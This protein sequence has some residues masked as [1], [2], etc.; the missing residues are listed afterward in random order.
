MLRNYLT[1]ALRNLQKYR[2]Y[3][4]I[5]ITGLTVGITCFLFIFLYI[6]DESGFDAYHA[7]VDRV[8]RLNFFAKLGD[9]L[10][11]LAAS[12][13]P[14]GPAFKEGAPEIE[15]FCRLQQHGNVTVR[16][17]N[18]IFN[19]AN[20]LFADS[21]LFKVFSFKL[22][23]GN[24]QNALAAPNS[25][26]LGQSVAKKYFGGDNPLGKSLK[27]GDQLCQVTGL[28]EDMPQNTHFQASIFRSL[29]SIDENVGSNWGN[30]N[31]YNYF[32]LREGADP[33]RVS[34]KITAIFAKNFTPILTE[35]FNT[36]WEDYE[37]AGNYARVELFPMRDIHL[38]GDL[39]EEL[40]ANGDV[41]YVYIFGIIGLFIL[42]LACIN[43]MN[44]ATARSAIR[45]KEVG[46]RK[47][48]GALRMDLAKQ[49]LSESVLMGLAALALSLVAVW[50][51]LPAFN[52]LSN[53]ELTVS[54]FLNPGF[55]LAAV[56]LA[57][58]IG[59]AAGSYPAFFL[60]AFQP[61]KVLKGGGIS[62]SGSGNLR[63]GLVVFQFFTTAVLLIGSLVVYQQLAFI[64]NQKLGFNKENV[65]LLNN[66]Y[67]L[68]NQQ[69]SFKE[70][71]LQNSAVQHASY[72]NA[73]PA[74]TTTNSSVV[75][76]GRVVTQENSILVNN[77]W[78]DRDYLKTLNMRIAA[79][80]D[81]SNA[82]ATDSSAVIVNETLAKSFGYPQKS[83]MGEE[84]SFNKDRTYHIVGVVKDFNF[85][86]L[87]DH[88]EPLAIY[89]GGY[90]SYLAIRFETDKVDA[91]VKNLRATWDEM[92]PGKPFDYAFL[93]QRFDKLYT[94]ESRMEKI[95]GVFAF[96]AIFIACIGLFGLATFMTEQRRRKYWVHQL[97][98]WLVFCQKTF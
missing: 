89:Q 72:C 6:K 5:N 63:S 94:S 21:T 67:L 41:K 83:V 97:R 22:L 78:A 77:W 11:H 14:A 50:L 51:L 76:K 55:L 20:A 71:M 68:R 40:A 57:G 29:T 64:R 44:L 70:K 96:L 85:S 98:G 45:A 87:R 7:N 84:I 33:K 82:M 32:L 93:D 86:S 23:K 47:A 12:P 91:L 54:A 19:E 59:V 38:H 49:F 27:M 43:F 13:K 18:Q 53:K 37:K 16:Y 39:D 79:G 65:L 60:S 81:F 24:P 75:Y 17:D 66:A 42:A 48:V 1:I 62:I 92:A 95:V 90:V 10:A 31:T 35:A 34:E 36:T 88:I 25:V 8:Y 56:T 61:G 2:F 74:I 46:V 58:L 80:R 52:N 26:V 9:Q 3:S 4:F 30:T 69:N 28:M 15:V 73:L